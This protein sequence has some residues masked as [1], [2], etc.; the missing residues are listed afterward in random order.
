MPVIREVVGRIED[1]V[2]GPDGRQMVR[3]HGVF[4]NQPHVQEGQVIQESLS[5]IT[6]RVV[7]TKDYTEEDTQDI[8]QRIR[9]RLGANVDVTVEQVTNIPRTKSG[10]FQAV[11][12]HLKK[13]G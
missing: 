2:I 5:Q 6:V 3:F 4:V 11:I 8:I 10:K 7:P 13:N 9:Q 1:V 12:S